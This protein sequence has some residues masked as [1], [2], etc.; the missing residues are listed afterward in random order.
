MPK[1]RNKRKK[2]PVWVSQNFLTSYK[3]INR[4]IRKTTLSN[5][6]HVIEIGP[7]KGHITRNLVKCC[8]YVSAIEIDGR[9]YNKL[10]DKFKHTD[11]VKLYRYDFL[12]W[13]LPKSG[14]YKVFSNIPFCI[15]TSIVKKL[16]EC[17]NAPVETWLIMEKGAAKRFMGK[18]S[19]SLR[20]LLL[21]PK[22]DVNIIYYFNQHDFHPKP[23][24]DVVLFHIKKKPQ[25]DIPFNQWKAYE[26]FITAAFKHGLRSLFTQNQL[27]RAFHIAGIENDA[28]PSEILYIQWLCLFR[29]YRIYV[30]NRK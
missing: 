27:I 8:K 26:H 25:P 23:G 28:T 29:C 15:T 11:N 18:P 24:V 16:T 30:L 7:G 4:I 6:D 19:E 9:L 2:A 22:F 20:S 17:K 21:K 12:K 5:Y 13:K 3:T 10:K 1:I 14:D